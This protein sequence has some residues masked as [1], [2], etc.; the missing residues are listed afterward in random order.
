MYNILHGDLHLGN[1]I[2]I[3]DNDMNNIGIIDYGIVYKL[4]QKIS[5]DLFNV[6]FAAMDSN[7][8][9]SLLKLLIKMVCPVKSEHAAIINALKEDKEI[10]IL[11]KDNF[12]SN[13]LLT[14]ITKITSF[15]NIS[16]DSNVCG[17][18]FCV[19]SALQTIEHVNDNK[20][21]IFLTKTYINRSIKI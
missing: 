19:M 2:L 13:V 9:D 11:Q 15:E 20:S 12:S 1:I 5:N 6:F 14:C 4:T 8:I 21:L 17:L 18:I 3:N 10:L 16:L 7:K